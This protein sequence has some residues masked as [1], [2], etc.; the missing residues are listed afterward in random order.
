MKPSKA[1]P[2]LRFTHDLEDTALHLQRVAGDRQ[3]AVVGLVRVWIGDLALVASV[4]ALEV[5]DAK[6]KLLIPAYDTFSRK[7]FLFKSYD[8][9]T[10]EIKIWEACKASS[11]ALTLPPSFIQ[12]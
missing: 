10:N 9:S 8:S 1:G 3:G 7:M 5:P 6:V 2:G 4:P 12:F 11:S